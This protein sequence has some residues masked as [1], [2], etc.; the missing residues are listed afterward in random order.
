MGWQGLPYDQW[1][2]SHVSSWLKYIGIKDKYIQKLEEEEVT[3]PVL[4]SLQREYFS[5]A[6]G[7]KGAQIEHLLHKR[8]ELFKSEPNKLQKDSSSHGKSKDDRKTES[9]SLGQEP[10][11]NSQKPCEGND[12][13]I[14]HV[15]QSDNSNSTGVSLLFCDYRKFDEHDH[16]FRYVKHNVLPP[17]TG[18]E[19]MIVPCHE[20]KSLEIAHKL[21]SK[22]LQTK[23]ASEVL[24]FACACMNMRTN[25]TIHFGIMDKVRGSHQHGE[26][27]GIP[28]TN[29]EDFVD[30]LDY[31]EKCFKGSNQQCDARS[32]IRNPRFIEVLDKD[33]TEKTWIIEYDV[34]PKASTVKDKLYSVGVPKFNEKDSKVKLEEKVPYH[35]VGA[36]TPRILDDDLVHF[37]QGLREK[38][39]Q[40]EEAESFSNQTTVDC[41]E[42]QKRKLTILLTSGKKYMDN[43]LFYIIVTNKFQPEH[44]DSISFLVHMKLFCVFD[45]D[46]DSKTSGL[47]G[48]Y[49]KHRANHHF[50]DDYANDGRLCTD[51]FIKHLQ[52]FEKTSWIFC[53]GRNNFLGGQKTCDEKTWIK[54]Q[55]K[56][57]KKAVSVICNEILPK[58]SFVVLFLLMSQVE[59]PIVETFHEFFA[60]MNGHDDLAVIS[61]SETIYKKWS[62]LAQVSCKMSAL[63]EISIVEMPLS[64]V[65]AT[66][67]SIQLS[68]NQHTR[69]LPAFSGGL[70]FSVAEDMML[71]LEIISADQ[72]DET[73]LEIMDQDEIN[74]IEQYFYQGGSID[75]I[76]FWLADKQLC[77]DIIQRD[78]YKEANTILENIVHRSNAVRSIEIVNIYH[79]PGSGGSTVARQ[80]L[81][82]WRTK[83]R[84]AVVKQSKEITTVCEHAVRL[85]EYEER[86]K[87]NCLPVLLLLEDCKPDYIDDLRR[88]FGNVIATKKISPSVLCFILLICK[89]SH[90]P[91]RMC[92]ASPSQTVAVTHEL[93]HVEKALF[94]KKLEQL[95]LQFETDFILTFVLMSEEFRHSYI[96]GFVKNLLHEIDHSSPTTRLIRFVALLNCYVHDSYMSVSHCEKSLGL[97]MHVSRTRYHAFVDEL[98]EEARLVF[99][100]LRKDTTNISSI[101]II[102]PLVAK[103]IL[104]QLS[105]HHP[106]SDI[107]MDLIND[108]L[109]INHRFGRDM[110]LMFIKALFIRRNKRSRGDPEDTAFSP[111]IEHV[112]TERNG[113]QK[114]VDLMKAAFISL[115]K[116]AYVA[117][118]LARLLYTNLRFEEARQWAEEAKSLLP[119]DTFVLNT[120]GQVYKKWFYHLVD[121]FEEKQPMPENCIEIIGTAVKG[122]SAFRAS[123]KTPKKET[124]TLDS[125]Y[126]GEVDVGCRLLKFLS[127]VDVFSTNTGNSELMKYLLTDYIPAEVNKPWTKFHHQL[128][129]LHKS[130]YQALEC[131]SEDLS[132]FRTDISEEDEE[133]DVRDPEQVY[134]PREWLTKKSAVYAAFFCNIP[135]EGTQTTES[136]DAEIVCP[137]E[138]LS[139]FQR[140]MKI[141]QLGGGNVTSILSFLYD[142]KPGRAGK[143]LETI[144]GVYP[145]NLRKNDLDQTELANFIFCQVALNCTLP[146]SSKLLSLQKLQELSMRFNTK[147]HNISSASALFLLSILFWPA[148]NDEE[149]NVANSQI[150]VSAID[151]LKRLFEQKIRHVAPRKSRMMT[152]FFL[153]KAQGLNKI[154]HRSA[155]ERHIKG[156]PSERKLQWLGGEVWKTKEVVQSLKRVEGWTEN[157]NLFV[158]GATRDSKIRIIP[159]YTAS[160]P[161]GN[162]NVTFYLGFSFDGVV[163]LDIQVME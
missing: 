34:V 155:I 94:S 141:Y 123:E 104:I 145:E 51:D 68:N 144:I 49:K 81:W 38:D 156:T 10:K 77:G 138:K 140:Q 159:R 106:Q 39:Q 134:S 15:E 119:H 2:E 115:G 1:T 67:Q 85:R 146:G 5:T 20:Y 17:E 65:D 12:K 55:K 88:E 120:L 114:A 127:G 161:N 46:P 162:E 13:E 103:E 52:L 98:S 53:N 139:P 43:S 41:R 62:S 24:R 8:N 37:I 16:D 112:S 28:I 71:S 79:H 128:K 48:R 47:C 133:L 100:H 147:G 3:G 152:H 18:I 101:R 135:D 111:L 82:S 57:L 58:R 6:I 76:N 113:V 40:R 91:E 153:A 89:R 84:C 74:H 80:I 150:L 122:I 30:A 23:V 63:K 44:L 75:W 61:E 73:K 27:I 121:T 110:F 64:H 160:L 131:I 31:I 96:E 35:R 36:N 92:R 93:T 21:D 86:E 148:T 154:V 25:G 108:K 126:Y 9:V 29:Q 90:D 137:T 109:L 130:L 69:S 125:S 118:Q 157:G 87:N 136:K 102:H 45:F 7:M 116:D 143:K 70:C 66:V 142:R 151:A 22:R 149:L 95:N 99:I 19:N 72:C 32:C 42:D 50:L 163:A 54:T 4:M 107:S 26:I 33:A 105:A 117:Q 132:Y 124:V 59:Q 158:K 11:P 129:G 56:K 14:I 78:A 83:V 60:E 97:A